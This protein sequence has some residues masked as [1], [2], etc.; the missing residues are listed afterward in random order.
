MLSW[1][2]DL[3]L[4]HGTIVVPSREIIGWEPLKVYLVVNIYKKTLGE[5]P[6]VYGL[7]KT[8]DLDKDVWERCVWLF[9]EHQGVVG[10]R[11]KVSKKGHCVY[12]YTSPT[13][14]R[15]TTIPKVGTGLV[16]S[17]LKLA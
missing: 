15:A 12:V 2:D 11:K 4:G 8:K 16:R 13:F 1:Y 17:L 3:H 14:I 9:V 6:Q 5:L 7:R 10:R